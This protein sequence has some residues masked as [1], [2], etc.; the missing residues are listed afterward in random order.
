M[1]R[2]NHNQDIVGLLEKFKEFQAEYPADLL[3]ER[4]ISFIRLIIRYIR[5]FIQN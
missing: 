3:Y 1:Y 4:R 5:T 2:L